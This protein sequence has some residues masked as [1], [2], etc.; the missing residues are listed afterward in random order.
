M[1]QNGIYH[2]SSQGTSLGYCIGP[3]AGRPGVRTATS[4][5]AILLEGQEDWV[6]TLLVAGRAGLSHAPLCFCQMHSLSPTA[7]FWVNKN[8]PSSHLLCRA[9]KE[10]FI[11]VSLTPCP[12]LRMQ[13]YFPP[14]FLFQGI[15]GITVTG[16]HTQHLM[17]R[18][19]KQ[20]KTDALRP[21]CVAATR[22]RVQVLFSLAVILITLKKKKKKRSTPLSAHFIE[23]AKNICNNVECIFNQL[24]DVRRC[25]CN[26][27]SLSSGSRLSSVINQS[28]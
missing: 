12:S 22:H 4:T 7:Q 19:P 2:P 17:T 6:E 1:I 8:K 26:K 10:Q 16:W 15:C 20:N 27:T 23:K 11:S 3:M 21:F 5:L 25:S 24:L 14:V 13:N 28:K 9:V 18:Q